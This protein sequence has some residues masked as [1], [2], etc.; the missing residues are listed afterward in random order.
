MA[1]TDDTSLRVAVSGIVKKRVRRCGKGITEEDDLGRFFR[2]AGCKVAGVRLVID[3]NRRGKS[4]GFGFV[5]FEDLESLD[6]ALKLHHK[7]AK[8]LADNDGKLRIQRAHAATDEGRTR[9][10][11]LSN[12]KNPTKE[13]ERTLAF[14][15]ARINE[16][17]REVMRKQHNEGNKVDDEPAPRVLKR[18]LDRR[19]SYL[20][21]DISRALLEGKVSGPSSTD[22][23]TDGSIDGSTD[24][25]TARP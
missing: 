3:A 8:G 23:S 21:A 10:P 9:Q 18:E 6:L 13:L 11:E 15:A 1:C 2:D 25:S 16:L 14:H 5:D 4:R 19:D 7:E 12:G 17:V 22:G 24:G 20:A